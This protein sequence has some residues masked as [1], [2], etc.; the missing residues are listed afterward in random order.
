MGRAL[1]ALLR[2]PP[3]RLRRP[4]GRLP[5]PPAEL[6]LPMGG[7]ANRPLGGP[8]RPRP[9]RL[10]RSNLGRAIWATGETDRSLPWHAYR[11]TP[12]P[13]LQRGRERAAKGDVAAPEMDRALFG[14][15]LART[16]SW[17]SAALSPRPAMWRRAYE[18][19][20]IGLLLHPF[21][22]AGVEDP[23]NNLHL[24]E[25]PEPGPANPHGHLDD[26]RWKEHLLIAC[27]DKRAHATGGR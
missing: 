27:N 11:T 17:S 19:A 12:A 9:G 2:R 23:S 20:A 4:P 10:R 3:G 13:A 26:I 6:R 14:A 15:A 21:G 16:H 1:G 18:A 24:A 25:P 5:R 22:N 7:Y 8:G